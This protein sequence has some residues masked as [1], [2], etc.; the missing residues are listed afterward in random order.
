[1]RFGRKDLIVSG[2]ISKLLSLN[3]VKKSSEIVALR[4][5]FDY[6]EVQIRSL[7]A[8][9]ISSDKYGGL[10]CPLLLQII[11]DD[12]ALEYTRK[13]DLGQELKVAD[14]VSFLQ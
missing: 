4:Q 3:P 7:E 12:L 2:H 11:P 14:L 13:T 5:V 6:V 10:L 1:M 8:L 9:G